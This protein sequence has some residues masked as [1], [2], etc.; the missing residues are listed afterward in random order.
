ME[1]PK[2][3]RDLWA[4]YFEAVTLRDKD[5]E[6]YL[7][8]VLASVLDGRTEDALFYLL[9]GTGKNGKSI[10]SKCLAAALGD[11]CVLPRPE[12]L[13]S[14]PSNNPNSASE[15]LMRLKDRY[16]VI[17][18]EMNTAEMAPDV[19]KMIPGGDFTS[20]RGIHEKE[21]TF[22][23]TCKALI[24]ANNLPE[25][26]DKSDGT[27]DKLVVIPFNAKF[28]D[29][30]KAPNERKI[31]LGLEKK[32]LGC[33][34]TLLAILVH[35]YPTYRKEG[36]RPN[37]FPPIVEKVTR[38]DRHRFN[39]AQEFVDERVVQKQGARTTSNDMLIVLQNFCD[40]PPKCADSKKWEQEVRAILEKMSVRGCTQLRIPNLGSGNVRGWEGIALRDGTWSMGNLAEAVEEVKTQVVQQVGQ[41]EDVEMVECEPVTEEVQDE[42]LETP[43]QTRIRKEIEYEYGIQCTLVSEEPKQKG[44]TTEGKRLRSAI[45]AEYGVWVWFDHLE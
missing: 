9:F 16:A 5:L 2:E 31:D 35:W 11:Y 1:H 34:D 17:V 32:L 39:V 10:L 38:E 23:Y 30:P 22:R 24:A 44:E 12:Q 43:A 36:V 13:C 42:K 26:T 19:A 8:K 4:A 27:W 7:M 14:K 18:P 37:V 6:K 20:G 25:I 33:A 15:P 3:K 28:I 21:G 45:K 29:N 40:T 41:E